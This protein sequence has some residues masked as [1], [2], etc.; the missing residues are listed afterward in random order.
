MDEAS[1]KIPKELGVE[2]FWFGEYIHVLGGWCA[3]KSRWT[4]ASAPGTLLDLTLCVSLSGR[5]FA[6]FK[7]SFVY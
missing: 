3:P 5:S 2:S 6:S 4:Q 1:I 7:M